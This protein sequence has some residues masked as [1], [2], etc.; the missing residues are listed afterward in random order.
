M[1]DNVHDALIS[2][3]ERVSAKRERWLGYNAE[4]G[5]GRVIVMGPAI[6]LMTHSIDAAKRALSSMDA[7]ECI[8]CLQDLRGYDS[9]D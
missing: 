2:E 7:V 1:S 9:D 3:I 4:L 8:A 5:S 6:A